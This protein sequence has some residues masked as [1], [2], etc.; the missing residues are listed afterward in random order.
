MLCMFK[1]SQINT[2][3]TVDKKLKDGLVNCGVESNSTLEDNYI[4]LI[5]LM[6]KF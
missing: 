2:I 5:V 6:T 1:K 3:S 4:T